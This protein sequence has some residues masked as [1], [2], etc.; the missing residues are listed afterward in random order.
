MAGGYSPIGDYGLIGDTRSAALVGRDGSIDWC[1]WPDFD[2]PAI[3]CRLLDARKGGS[4]RVGF[5]NGSTATRAYVAETNVLLSTFTSDRGAARV[6]DFMP[7]PGEERLSGV[8]VGSRRLLRRVEG[9]EGEM[10]LTVRFHPTFDYA[11]EAGELAVTPTGAVARAAGATLTLTCAAPLSLDADGAL[12]GRMR[13]RAGERQWVNLC[14]ECADRCASVPGAD[15]A[16]AQLSATVEGWRRWYRQCTYEGPYHPLVRRSALALKLLTFAPTGAVV[17]APTTSLPEEIGGVRNWDYRYTW[18]RDS[19]MTLYSLTAIGYHRE[20]VAFFDWLERLCLGCR[21]AP[22]ILYTVRGKAD[23]PE[24]ALDHLEGYRGSSPVRIGNAAASQVQLDVF[25]EVLDAAYFCFERLPR[26][27]DR[28]LGRTL[29]FFADQA[30]ERWREPDYGIW[31]V[32]GDPRQFLYSKLLCWVALDRAVELAEKGQLRGRVRRWRQVR[33]EIRTAILN[34]GYD[35]EAGAFTQV[36]G[37]PALDASALAIPLV[38]FLP[39]T[40]P[41]VQS[42]VQAIQ[43]RLSADRLVYRYLGDDG[44]P[45]GEAT[46]A[47]CS[48]WLVEAL[49]LG[50]RIDEARELFERVCGYAND[51][52]LMA[53]EIAPASGELLGNFPQGF[54]HLALIRSALSIAKAEARGPE[55]RAERPAER[56]REVEEVGAAGRTDRLRA[57]E[58]HDHARTGR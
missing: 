27:L 36:L 16:E 20:A 51:L 39:S 7:L 34:E 31:E 5:A 17:A 4:F 8:D 12:V 38:G 1:C 18:L 54:T 30:A 13:V 40:D 56:E 37:E 47:L 29:A 58:E 32:R 15:E 3:F 46:F 21:G 23:V 9:V 52:G 25:G 35:G 10:E 42:T 14:F 19:A 55:E 2:S 50:G 24:R 6:T 41:R 49:A 22:Q 45:G 44:L 33:E 26:E 11:R 57:E 43:E 53:E 28:G 48:F